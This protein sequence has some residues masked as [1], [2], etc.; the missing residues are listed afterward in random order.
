M[1]SESQ[2]WSVQEVGHIETKKNRAIA[3]PNIYQHQVQP[4][5]LLD[6]TKPGHRKII[7]FFLCDPH[8]NDLPTTRTIAPQQPEFRREVEDRLREGSMGRVPEEIFEQIMNEL[9][10]TIREEE[11]FEYRRELMKERASFALNS[12]MIQGFCSS[13][14]EH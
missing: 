5:R 11:A 14:C 6:P 1:S 7:V 10:E 12:T 9:P 8:H 2:P 3:F 4:F 13:W